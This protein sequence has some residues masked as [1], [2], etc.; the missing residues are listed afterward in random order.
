M[1][2][3]NVEIVRRFIDA[4]GRSFEVYWENPRSIA[5][6][7]EAGDLWPEQ[8]EVF[9]YAAPEVEWKAVFLDETHR[10]YLQIAKVWDDY[11]RWAEDYRVELQEV[12]D[13]GDNCVYAVVSVV[14]KAKTGG[15]SMETRLFDL[16]TL[17]NGRIVRLEEF[18]S[19]EQALAAAGLSE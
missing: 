9:S 18:T 3:E 8:R 5:A 2:R 14:G 19:R 6:A 4:M 11:L 13:L 16:F 15:T 7:V 1:S 12:D 10:G 17:R